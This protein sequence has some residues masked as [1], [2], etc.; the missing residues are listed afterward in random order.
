MTMNQ[1]LLALGIPAIVIIAFFLGFRGEGRFSFIT[2]FFKASAEGRNPQPVKVPSG[3]SIEGAEA[4]GN[5][6]AHAV[7][8]GG[9]SV[10]SVKAKGDVTAISEPG[11]EP[12]KT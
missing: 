1:T 6:K 3:A 4:H 2:K 8:E 11:G 10:K 5:I 12:P 7:G 9:A